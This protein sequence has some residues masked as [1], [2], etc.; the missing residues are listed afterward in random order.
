MSGDEAQQSPD[1]GPVEAL[2]ALAL[3]HELGDHDRGEPGGLAVVGVAL[4]GD[5]EAL[6]LAASFDLL[7]P[8]ASGLR[9]RR[10]SRAP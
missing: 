4:G 10:P 5:G 1:L 3:L 8:E 9:V 2:A 6:G 7:P